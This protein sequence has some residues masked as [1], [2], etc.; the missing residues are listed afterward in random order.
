MCDTFIPLIDANIGRIVN[1]SSDLGPNYVR[2][3]KKNNKQFF[4]RTD[5]TW[6]EIEEYVRQ[7]L[8]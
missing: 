3:L 5:I 4:T 6:E 7:N 2:T 8:S 1:V